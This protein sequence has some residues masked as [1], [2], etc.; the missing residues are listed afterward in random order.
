VDL[1]EEECLGVWW[2][3]E[4]VV[5]L[6]GL[7]GEM[8]EEGV[9]LAVGQPP[10]ALLGPGVEVGEASADNERPDLILVLGQLEVEGRGVADRLPRGELSGVDLPGFE[11]AIE[12]ACPLVSVLVHVR[13]PGQ[14]RA[15]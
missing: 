6:V 12:C 15:L 14:Q 11:G 10:L 5:V 3:L 7:A 9:Y 2:V 1:C 4:L 8:P 13:S